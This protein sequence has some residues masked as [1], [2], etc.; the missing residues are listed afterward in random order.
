MTDDEK[1]MQDAGAD[2]NVERAAARAQ[3]DAWLA[4]HNLGKGAGV[5]LSE[6]KANADGSATPAMSEAKAAT[7][8]PPGW[9]AA[10]RR[11]EANALNIYAATDSLGI[12]PRAGEVLQDRVVSTLYNGIERRLNKALGPIGRL[13]VGKRRRDKLVTVLAGFA[14]GN[15]LTLL[16]VGVEAERERKGRGKAGHR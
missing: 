2:A 3:R 5:D 14:Y 7:R 1:R 13:V 12:F 10:T 11:L 9:N 6:L 15:G 8:E 4:S 16:I